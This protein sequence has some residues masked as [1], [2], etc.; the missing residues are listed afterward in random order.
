MKNRVMAAPLH[1]HSRA[2]TLGTALALFL[3]AH[4][5]PAQEN[6]VN[7]PGVLELSGELIVKPLV[8]QPTSEESREVFELA[9][10]A[11]EEYEVLEHEPTLDYYL[12]RVPAGATE[13]EVARDL[14]ARGLF[15]F[16]EPN[17]RAFPTDARAK[18]I[19]TT[20]RIT[21]MSSG[22]TKSSSL[23]VVGT[24]TRVTPRR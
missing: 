19:R 18:T 14:M 16:V 6:F 2:H 5:A 1:D 4:R 9:L 11:I 10:A 17:W 12:I 21:S 3:F 13:T 22:I 20:T 7:Q 15:R 8:S 24:C 23:A